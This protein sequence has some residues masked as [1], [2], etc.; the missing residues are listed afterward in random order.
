MIATESFINFRARLC[1]LYPS[2]QVTRGRSIVAATVRAWLLTNGNVR[3]G[4]HSSPIC[5][6][7]AGLTDRFRMS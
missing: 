5:R 4:E 3:P 6:L 1:R 7:S 2:N